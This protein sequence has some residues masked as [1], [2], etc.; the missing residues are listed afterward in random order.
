MVGLLITA[1]ATGTIFLIS[2]VLASFGIFGSFLALMDLSVSNENF[3]WKCFASG[4]IIGLSTI[5]LSTIGLFY[6]VPEAGFWGSVMTALGFG[7]AFSPNFSGQLA[8]LG[9]S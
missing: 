1:V 7:T 3:D 2:A 9:V 5:G 6:M 4:L 8:C